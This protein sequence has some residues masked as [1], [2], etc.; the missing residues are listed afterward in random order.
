ME[1]GGI[2]L[3]A[4]NYQLSIFGKFS[5][6]PTPEIIA[7]LMTKINQETQKTMLPNMIT[8]QQI[9]IPSNRVS[10]I[11]N[12]GFITQD[13][14]YNI[15][16]LNERIDVTY[17]RVNETEISQAGFYVFA[18]KALSV[19]IDN[20]GITAN[21]LAAN[22]QFIYEMQDFN[23]LYAKGKELLKNADYYSGKNYAE[24][25]LRT[26]AL[27]SI[28]INGFDEGINVI[29]DISSA[30]AAVGKALIAVHTDINTFP[31]NTNLRF[32]KEALEPFV[33]STMPIASDIA[34]GVERLIVHE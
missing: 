29:T 31:Q 23:S 12:L 25:S 27:D 30:R 2:M 8:S 6:T 11:S 13:Q 24:W 4:I 7:N 1:D 20:S 3:K 9:E 26:N 28:R 19:I 33:E 21:R 32:G 14:M 18:V 22:T 5:I 16:I 17:N 15:A 10:T 34:T